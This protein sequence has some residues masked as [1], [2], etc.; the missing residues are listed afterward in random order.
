MKKLLIEHTSQIILPRSTIQESIEKNGGKLI[1]RNVLLQRAD[2]PNRNKRVYSKRILERELNEY[3]NKIREKRAYSELDHPN[4]FWNNTEILTKNSSWKQFKDMTIGEEVATLNL[5]T[6]QL[7]WQPV[8]K[9]TNEEYTGKMISMQ[10]RNI[11]TLVTPNHR[12]YVQGR[13][14]DLFA[15]TAQEIHDA[16]LSK[17]YIYAS[18]PTTCD[19]DGEKH[20]QWIIEKNL[21]Y[22]GSL[23][24]REIQFTDLIINAEAFFA[25]LGFYLAEGYVHKTGNRVCISQNEGER[26][27]MFRGVLESM[28]MNWCEYLNKNGKNICFEIIDSRLSNYLKPLGNKYTKFI[29]EDVKKA[30]K[31][32]L[33]LLFDWYLRGDGSSVVYNGYRRK[34]VFTVSNQLINDL[35]EISLKIGFSSINKIQSNHLMD[36]IIEG[37]LIKKENS[38]PLNRLWIKTSKGIYL[39]FRFLKVKEVEYNGTIHCVNV[40]NGT[41]YCKDGTHPFWSGNSEEGGNVISLKNVCQAIIDARWKGNEIYGDVEILKTPS[42]NIVKELL[43]AGFRVGQSSRGL[44]SVEPLREGSDDDIVE[45][46]DDF[47][48]ITLADCVSDPSTH[49][50]DMIMGENLISENNS[51]NR[52]KNSDN[53]YG[54]ELNNRYQN[55]ENLMREIRCEL[56]GMC[57][58]K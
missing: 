9:V 49:N 45:V 3:F 19:W 1:V 46:Q 42:G 48:L 4:C 36:R 26:A 31:K 17:N 15:I 6:K 54:N 41:I 11:D 12:F 35:Q 33:T 18:I 16:Q 34:T 47:E 38:K 22:R 39:D 2:T 57:C 30:D 20:E 25:F 23:K 40:E 8:L 28:N 52:F 14:G 56:G 51:G 24:N 37:R 29:P 5:A 21:N 43:L 13:N 27:E 44:G 55:I 7:E 10:G 53:S 58:L 32:L 50:A